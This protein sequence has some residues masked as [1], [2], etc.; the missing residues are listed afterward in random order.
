MANPR[1]RSNLSNRGR[2]AGTHSLLRVDERAIA[3]DSELSAEMEITAEE[4]D[5][6]VRLLGNDLK[7]FLSEA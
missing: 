3:L 1:L 2:R 6:I 4:L 5:A 7:S